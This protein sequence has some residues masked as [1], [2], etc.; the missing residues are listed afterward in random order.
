MNQR[1]DYL[2]SVNR[3]ID[4]VVANLEQ[5]LALADVARVAAFSPFHFHRV[6]Q[7]LVGETLA[8]FVRRLRLERALGMMA[9]AAD[10]DGAGYTRDA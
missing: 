6:F 4:H 10:R 9:R 7:K 1:V 2:A 5:P 3:A 8:A